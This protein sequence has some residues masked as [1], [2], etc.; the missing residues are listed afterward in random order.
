MRLAGEAVCHGSVP[1]SRSLS[2]PNDYSLCRGGGEQKQEIPTSKFL[3][4]G[5]LTFLLSKMTLAF[6]IL[7]VNFT[8][9]DE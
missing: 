1:S 6:E 9:I 8:G 3:K 4:E 5:M 7:P 2:S